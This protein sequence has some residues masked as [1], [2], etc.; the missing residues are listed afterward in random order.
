MDAPVTAP[1]HVMSCNSNWYILFEP[2]FTAH[3]VTRQ[4]YVLLLGDLIFH[5]SK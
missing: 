3:M 1:P 4:L 5:L 2:M